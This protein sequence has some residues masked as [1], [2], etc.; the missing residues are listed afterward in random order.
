MIV[1]GGRAGQLPE[2]LLRIQFG[3]MGPRTLAVFKYLVEH[4]EP[5]RT[6]H[7]KLP[8]IPAAC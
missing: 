1:K 6:R 5:P 4:G 7:A 8:A 3:R 2:P